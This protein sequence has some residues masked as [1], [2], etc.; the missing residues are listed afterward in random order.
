M[1]IGY[2]IGTTVATMKNE[3][4]R[5][6]KLLLVLNADLEGKTHGEP[7]IAIDTVDAGTGDLVVITEGSSARQTEFTTGLP[8]DAVIVA[9]IDSLE[10]SGTVTFRK[11]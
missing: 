1:R 3:K 7:F 9:V 2:V 8:V 4:L 10:T 11:A 5:G 6:H